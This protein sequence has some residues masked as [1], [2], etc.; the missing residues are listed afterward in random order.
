MSSVQIKR[1]ETKKDLKDFIEF[2][3]DLYEGNP[4][5]VPSLYSDELN[6]LSKDRNAAFDF[7]E[8]EYYLALKDGR[9]AGRVAA[10]INH[11][12]NEKW[13]KK[14]VRF[15]WIDF[16]DDMEVS[17]ALFQ[18]VEDYGRQKGM[19][20]AV[21]PL[22]F[23]D[24]DPEGML[25]WGFDRLGTM[26]TSYNYAYY[27]RHME[28]LGGWVKD[29]DYVEYYLEV[30]EKAPEKYT[31]IAEM[32]EKRYNLHVRKLTK[33]DIFEGGYGKKLF[34]LINL[35]YADLYGFSELSDR[36]I[37]QYIRM[38]FPLADL[39]LV[40]AVED[41]NKD[42][43]LVGIAITIPSLSRALQKC[44]R[45]RL[46]PFGWW[47]LLRAIKWHKTEAVDLLLIGVLPEY[48]AKG[49]NALVFADLIPRYVEYGFK[50]GET[51][52]EMETNEGVQSQWGPLDPI[53]HK[54]RR[55]YRK[56]LTD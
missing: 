6:T 50:W 7:C 53:N 29:N 11:K 24:M 1:V 34:D 43:Q 38:Y 33:R 37:D 17:R 22:G 56:S 18:A 13:K 41:G 26:A 15:G 52:V 31:K 42:N 25:T 55:C 20:A 14:D 5:D 21:G 49:A 36:Q 3:Y 28:Q 32:V 27:P 40:T 9:V 51:Q 45:G 16:I 35:T 44:R 39:N 54:K 10:I 30:P 48:R 46:L 4:Y 12:A 8:A 23:T 47:H 19:E 2:H